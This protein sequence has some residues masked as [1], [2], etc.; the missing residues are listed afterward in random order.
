MADPPVSVFQHAGVVI[1]PFP[2]AESWVHAGGSLF[3]EECERKEKCRHYSKSLH[4]TD[5]ADLG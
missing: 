5:R 2:C 1:A 3:C 4:H